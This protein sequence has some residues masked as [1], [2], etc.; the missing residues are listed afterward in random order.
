VW[1]NA[2]E[3]NRYVWREVSKRCVDT[4]RQNMKASIKEKRSL[5]FYNRLTNSWE[6]KLYIEVCTQEARRGIGWRKMGI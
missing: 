4:E 6:K 1:R 3:N 5:V 2:E